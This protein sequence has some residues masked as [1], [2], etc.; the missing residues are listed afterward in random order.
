MSTGWS[1][2]GGTCRPRLPSRRCWPWSRT[3]RNATG[4]RS[5]A[6]SFPSA[7]MSVPASAPNV[8]P[9]PC[10]T[11]AGRWGFPATDNPLHALGDEL[12][13]LG[14]SEMLARVNDL[15]QSLNGLP[16]LVIGRGERR[17]G[18]ADDVRSAEVGDDATGFERPRDA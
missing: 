15:A 9:A 13:T 1:T 5:T 7:N 14:E 8:P 12:A 17:R 2:A 3:F 18:E 6:C 10:S 11:C 16:Q 4:C